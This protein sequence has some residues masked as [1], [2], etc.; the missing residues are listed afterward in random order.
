MVGHFLQKGIRHRNVF[1]NRQAAYRFFSFPGSNLGR[2][3]ILISNSWLFQYWFYKQR[4]K[5]QQKN[6]AKK[7]VKVTSSCPNEHFT[8]Q[9]KQTTKNLALSKSELPLRANLNLNLNP[10]LNLRCVKIQSFILHNFTLTCK[11]RMRLE[12]HW[13]QHWDLIFTTC[14]EWS[15]LSTPSTRTSSQPNARSNE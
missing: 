13:V 6:V 3:N 5:K 15:S 8:F 2:V 14:C 9:R 12:S 7:S 11:E 1:I 4:E 10:N